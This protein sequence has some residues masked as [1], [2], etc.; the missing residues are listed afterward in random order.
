MGNDNKKGRLGNDGR[1]ENNNC[2]FMFS[3]FSFSIFFYKYLFENIKKIPYSKINN[4]IN[5]VALE[6]KFMEKITRRECV[7][8]GRN[9]NK[10]KIRCLLMYS[11]LISSFFAAVVVVEIYDL[12]N[13]GDH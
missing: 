10:I 9:I 6:G 7:V 12:K 13:S 4:N 8:K 2:G 5:I 11:I 3:S 1:M